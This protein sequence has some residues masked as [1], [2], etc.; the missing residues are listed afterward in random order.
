MFFDVVLFLLSSLITGPNSMS[1]S[2]LVLELLQL[3]FIRDW[4]EIWKSE[5][6]PSEFFPVSEELLVELV[7]PKFA[8][9]FLMKC[10]RMLQKARVAAFT[11]SE[12]LRESQQGPPS[13]RLVLIRVNLVYFNFVYV[14][15]FF[16]IMELF[17]CFGTFFYPIHELEC[18]IL[19]Q[20]L[21]CF[22]PSL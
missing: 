19:Y 5:I 4:P 17:P 13:A 20:P 2:S 3:S 15:T 14:R 10:N 16:H 1:I 11:V 22:E 7:I 21:K 9:I 12:L 18:V 6:P 8:Q